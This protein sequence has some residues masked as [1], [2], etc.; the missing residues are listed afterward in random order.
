M[1]LFSCLLYLFRLD[2]FLGAVL[3]C[4]LFYLLR[5]FSFSFCSFFFFYCRSFPLGL[6]FCILFCLAICFF[7]VVFSDCCTC[8]SIFYL[9]L[10]A[11]LGGVVPAI[12][13]G[14]GRKYFLSPHKILCKRRMFFS[15]NSKCCARACNIDDREGNLYLL[16]PLPP[17]PAYSSIHL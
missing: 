17:P 15:Y 14:G 11:V 9:G 3:F 12:F 7:A 5:L 10:T 16:P 13:L 1:F 6:F 8:F 2:F 4:Y